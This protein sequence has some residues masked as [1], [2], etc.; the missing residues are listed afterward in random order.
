MI[1]ALLTTI[2]AVTPTATPI[3]TPTATIPPVNAFIT[4]GFGLEI[5]S[6]GIASLGVIAT[7]ILGRAALKA[8][9]AANTASEVANK[10]AQQQLKREEEMH[11]QE[12]KIAVID[13]A[14]EV[15]IFFKKDIIEYNYL[16]EIDEEEIHMFGKRIEYL[17][18]K[19]KMIFRDEVFMK[20]KK[21]VECASDI[22]RY[23]NICK[24]PNKHERK[25]KEEIIFDRIAQEYNIKKIS[26]DK[27]PLFEKVAIL[28]LYIDEGINE[29]FE[30]YRLN[31]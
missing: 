3:P 10:I 15:Y 4:D 5:I 13:K 11:K 19:A 9:K 31:L 20:V 1:Y 17:L 6:I 8:S 25:D 2:S 28:K 23:V 14:Y 29:V 22:A 12:D 30:E 16:E 26:Y 7:F 18:Y 27:R 24:H 21:L